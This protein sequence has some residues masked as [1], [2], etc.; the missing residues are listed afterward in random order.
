MRA[1]ILILVFGAT[2]VCTA[3]ELPSPGS[4][5]WFQWQTPRNEAFPASCC[6]QLRNN[7]VIRST[8][9]LDD[10]DAHFRVGDGCEPPG[11]SLHI[12]VNMR[13]GKPT[14]I[15]SYDSTCQTT[16]SSVVNDLG[17]FSA[18]QS[19]EWLEPYVFSKST[20]AES[21]IGAIAMHHGDAGFQSLVH[22]IEN[23]QYGVRNRE[24]ALLWL[25]QIDSDEVFQYLDRL[26]S[27][28]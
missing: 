10:V 25:A 13:N 7:D 9:N 16:A 21:A 23:S 20:L 12:F 14:R 17:H 15:R 2:A 1:L 5:G 8:C 11:D 18:K 19:I 24:H 27:N 3:G 4:D 26:L 22:I 28:R 6:Y